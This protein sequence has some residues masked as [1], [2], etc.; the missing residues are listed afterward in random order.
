MKN[1]KHYLAAVALADTAIEKYCVGGPDTIKEIKRLKEVA[2]DLL[3]FWDLDTT[4]EQDHAYQA[5]WAIIADL[6]QEDTAAAKDRCP[7]CGAH[8]SPAEACLVDNLCHACWD[9]RN[10]GNGGHAE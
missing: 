7:E 3:E 10:P 6:L 2:D 9:D 4:P 8:I 5:K 1:G